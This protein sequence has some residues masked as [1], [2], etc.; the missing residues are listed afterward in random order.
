MP[1]KHFH[2]RFL[3]EAV[4]SI[5]AQTD[6]AWR[7]L[8]VGERSRMAAIRRVL[9]A[10]LTDPRVELIP[11]CGRKLAGKFNTGM[12]HAGTPF[13]SILLGDDL[14]APEAIAVLTRE[15]AAHPEVDFF[16]SARR[17]VDDDGTP[18]S[19]VH[20]ARADVSPQDFV[21]GHPVR[22]L[23]CWRRQLALDIGGMDES[24]NS[25]G[26]D[27]F[28]FPWLMSDHGA[29]F[30]AVQEC[31]YI[32]RDHRAGYR[33][34]THLP[35][36]THKREMVRIMEKHGAPPAAIE[37]RLRIAERSYLQQCLYR[38]RLDRALKAGRTPAI[39]R[40]PYA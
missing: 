1:V 15:I 31:L 12:R 36:K 14:W 4:D 26:P 2:E 35:L 32:V 9:A 23:L 20:P 3:L 38:S 8:V 7:L 37:E 18:V 33:L 6:P 5:F 11:T 28:D 16:H 40:E 39:W 34:T 22:H 21:D 24:L 17:F 10:P 19:S 30:K 13:V 27:D 25:V 29:C